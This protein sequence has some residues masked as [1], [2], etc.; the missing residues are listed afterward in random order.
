MFESVRPKFPLAM[1]LT[2]QPRRGTSRPKLSVSLCGILVLETTIT[3][4]QRPFPR[5]CRLFETELTEC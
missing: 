5:Y 4:P 2:K 3:V 1:L